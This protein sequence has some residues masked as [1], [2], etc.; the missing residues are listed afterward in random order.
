MQVTGRVAVWEPPRRVVFVGGAGVGG[1]AFEWMAE[2]R[3]D[4]T[5]LVR[6]INTGFG[7]DAA[8]EATG[9]GTVL[10]PAI[11]KNVRLGAVVESSA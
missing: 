7:A 6:F 9:G 5:C 1:L 8:G 2:T 11:G 3:E 10:Y 4:A